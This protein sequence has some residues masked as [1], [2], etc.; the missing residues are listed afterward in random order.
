[1]EPPQV[2]G[3]TYGILPILIDKA[4]K[5]E[6]LEISVVSESI[7]HLRKGAMKDFLKILKA[8]GRYIDQ[9][10]NRTHLTYTFSNG[11]YIEFFSADQEDK[12]RGP[13]RHILY[14]NECNNLLFDTYHQLAIRTSMEVWLDF[15]PSGEFWAYTELQDD[16]D[17]EWLTLTYKDNEGLPSSIVKEIEKAKSKAYVDPDGNL[18]LESNIKN[19][20]WDNWWK[21]YGMGLLGS[22]DG[23]ILS[24]WETILGIPEEAEYLGSGLD[25]GYTNDPSALVDVYKWNGKRIIDLV[26]YAKGQ[27]ND[28]LAAAIEDRNVYADSAEPKS[29]DY[30]HLKCHKNIKGVQKGPDSVK[31]GLELMQKQDYLITKR[32]VELIKEVRFYCWDKD[33]SGKKLNKPADGQQDHGMDAWRYAEMMLIGKGVKEFDVGW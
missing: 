9:N 1:M 5:T 33:K 24:N 27:D 25:F 16:D 17:I 21:V 8:T 14:I 28:M 15:N 30:I 7:P 11:S 26:L 12:V 18:F 23:V 10:W 29:I 4:I 32:S 13:R 22:L 31:F 19:A 20:F 6:G 2:E 3:K